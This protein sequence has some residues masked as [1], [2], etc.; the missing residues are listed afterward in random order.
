MKHPATILLVLSAFLAFISNARADLSPEWR[1][2]VGGGN[3]T[4]DQTIDACTAIIATA[5]EIRENAAIAHNNRGL[6]YN[7][8][9]LYDGAIQDYDQAI[10][11]RPEYPD[12]YRN[13]GDSYSNKGQLDRAIQDYD[14]AIKLKPDYADAYNNRGNAY[15]NRGLYDLAIADFNQAIKF[16]TRLGVAIPYGNRGFAYLKKGTLRDLGQAIA[17]SEQALKLDPNLAYFRGN[18]EEARRAKA[19]L[20]AQAH[21]QG[22]GDR[23]ALVIGNAIYDND[24]RIPNAENDASDVA[25]ALKKLGYTVTAKTNLRIADM[26]AELDRFAKTSVGA[27]AAVV[28]YSG[29][30]QQMREEGAE[31]SDDYVIPVDALINRRAD[32]AKN[33]IRVD[34]LTTSVVAAK[35]LRL[36]IID[37]CRNSRFWSETRGATRRNVERPGVLIIYS[38]QPG[39]VAIDDLGDGNRNSPFARAFLDSLR[40]GPKRDVRLLFSDVVGRTRKLT[41][42]D[43]SPQPIDGLASADTIALTTQ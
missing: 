3:Y 27:S 15:T 10:R 12:A 21:A 24:R 40:E 23:V 8:K 20:L 39:N 29:H 32:V 41:A 4:P 42:G 34:S 19:A 36:V 14:Q 22:T 9:G 16:V 18:L 31:N 7:A 43:Q 17:D 37:A 1:A 35:Q 26:R 6:A 28:W 11:L 33:A 30:G 38:A 13:R 5:R 25:E 2:C